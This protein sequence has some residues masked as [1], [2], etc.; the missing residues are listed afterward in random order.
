MSRILW[1]A[2]TT[3]FFEAGLDRGVLFLENGMAVPWNGLISVDEASGDSMT[4]H[5]V[6]GRPFL[7]KP[8]AKE[9]E[10]TIAA[11][12]YPDELSSVMGF[13]ES[14]EAAGLYLDSQTG[15]QFGLCYRTHVGNEVDG[16]EHAYKIHLVYNA[17]VS[18]PGLGA[19]SFAGSVEPVEF[20]W[21]IKAVPENIDEHR[22]TAHL[23]VDTRKTTPALVKVLE[24]I[25]YGTDGMP[26]RLPPAQ[27]VYDILSYGDEIVVR[28]LGGDFYSVSGSNANVR[29]ISPDTFRVDTSEDNLEFLPNGTFRIKSSSETWDE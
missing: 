4:S 5:F 14:S 25:I 26:P 24:D 13:S 7:H 9:F 8:K 10:A 28:D 23:V 15:T 12:T 18:A 16:I 11:Y 3:R 6:D 22:N 27:E 21:A 20:S 29:L 1:N 17:A 2:P 19:R